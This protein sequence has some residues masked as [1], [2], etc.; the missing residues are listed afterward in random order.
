[1]E[2]IEEN[3]N[4]TSIEFDTYFPNTMTFIEQFEEIFGL[5]EA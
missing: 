4:T 5:S 1:M 2:N 3:K